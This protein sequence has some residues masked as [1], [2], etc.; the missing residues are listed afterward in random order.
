MVLRAEDL[1]IHSVSPS[2]KELLNGRDVNGLPINEVF[3]GKQED[4]LIK[5]L[6]TAAS[7]LQT[8]T[9]GPILAGVDGDSPDSVQFVHTIVPIS[10]TSGLTV[11]RLFLYSEKFD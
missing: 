7:E 2:Y 9:T 6:R 4:S 1:S 11:T 3:S 8:L 5:T 10:D